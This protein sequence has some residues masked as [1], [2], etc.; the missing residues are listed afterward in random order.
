[1][2]TIDYTDRRRMRLEVEFHFAAAHR[3]PRY[4]GPCRRLHGH[5]YGF[6]VALEG[7]VDPGSGMIFDFG[8][9]KKMVQEHV[10]SRVDH[11][12][13]NEVL[14]NP[15]AENI[16]RWIWEVLEPHLPGLCEV[17]LH[18]IPDSCVT[19]RGPGGRR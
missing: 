18:E 12:D 7:E 1:M 17:R 2:G 6:F 13:L 4:D 5:N 11:R 9:L 19:Y 16:A 8:D 3:L 10:L 15:T 14:A